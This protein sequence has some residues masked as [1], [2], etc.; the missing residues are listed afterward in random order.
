MGPHASRKQMPS[1]PM[2]F[3]IAPARVPTLQSA[4]HSRGVEATRG[5]SDGAVED[6][7]K[8]AV[9]PKLHCQ[10]RWVGVRGKSAQDERQTC[11]PA[12]RARA[13][14]CWAQLLRIISRP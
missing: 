10:S 8:A 13:S 2:R 12:W 11:K 5:A 9:E 7:C 6:S 1:W 4:E 3:V 14:P